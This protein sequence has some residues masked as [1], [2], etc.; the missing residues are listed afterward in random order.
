MRTII[1]SDTHLPSRVSKQKFNYLTS[2]I[3]PADRVII[4]GDFWDGFLT[5]FDKFLRGGWNKL[6][7]LLLERQ[8]IY[9]YG[10][11]DRAEWSDQ[12]VNLFSVQQAH[13]LTL[14]IEDQTY[15]LTHGHTIK[16]SLEERYP[17]LNHSVPLRVGSSMDILHKLVWGRRFLSAD[18]NHNRKLINWVGEHL[19]APTTLIA[20]HTHFPEAL[21]EQRFINAGFI[22]CGYGHY[23]A[24]TEQ[25]IQLVRD[26]Y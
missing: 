9:I 25:G 23:V 21:P 18:R 4:L 6:F 3:E 17:V 15:F 22:G 24:I 19:P 2:I 13:D 11:H 7:P 16:T 8:S 26:R 20:G 14:A 12:R 10:N 1:F 5:N